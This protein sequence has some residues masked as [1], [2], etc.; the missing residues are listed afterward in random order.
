MNDSRVV[1]DNLLRGRKSPRMGTQENIWDDTLRG[2]TTQGYPVNKDGKPVDP[3]RHFGLDMHGAGGWFDLMPIRGA[4][5]VVQETDEWIIKR[6][7]AGASLKWWKNKSGTPE[8]MDFRMTSREI[9][10][11]D[12]RSHLLAM[13]PD[14]VYIEAG[15]KSQPSLAKEGFWTYYGHMFIW[16]HMRQTM[17]DICLY[18]SLLLDKEWIRDFNRVYTD[19]FK[20]HYKYLFEQAGLPDGIW[21]FE[22]MGYKNGLF[23]SPSIL[24]DLI[25]PYFIELVEFFHSYDLPV[26][27]HS[28]GDIREAMPMILAAKF[29]GLNPMEAKAGC[30][31]LEFA[32]KYGRD[33]CLVGGLDARI[34]ESGDRGLIR[35]SV[36]TI[37]RTM[38]ETGARYVFASDHSISTNVKYA[39]Y[40]LALQVFKDNWLY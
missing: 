3:M 20:A 12:Y 33:I 36:E 29:D 5:E 23:C 38:R 30:D 22:D 24:Q 39:D 27:L 34:L 8:H 26:V 32:R 9:W 10:D 1:I 40:Q 17:G 28:C 4:E 13:D 16:E 37:A 2:W 31:V 21:M 15:E 11:R 18:E 19:F 25:F 6:N 14:R 35:K 7:G